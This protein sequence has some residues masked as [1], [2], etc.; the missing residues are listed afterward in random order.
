MLEDVEHPDQ[1]EPLRK[2]RVQHIALNKSGFREPCT[3]VPQA[4]LEK[5]HPD[6][7]A[8]AACVLQGSQDVASPAADFEH[9]V[10]RRERAHDLA[11]KGRDQAVS[12]VKPEVALF[13]H[14]Q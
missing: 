2:G 10:T 11:G 13:G 8:T 5:V 12:C 1:L 6:H 9:P 7:R 3:R 4:V 14:G